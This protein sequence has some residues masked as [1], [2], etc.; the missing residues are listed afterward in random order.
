M[1]I[2][3]R[4]VASFSIFLFDRDLERATYDQQK[5]G[6]IY[7]QKESSNI[8]SLR[9]NNKEAKHAINKPLPALMQ[10]YQI[11]KSNFIIVD[12]PLKKSFLNH[13][14]SEYGER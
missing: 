13:A 10:S 2:T 7:H 14:F 12:F 1:G 6:G 8:K 9:H 5:Y 11:F 3:I 4:V